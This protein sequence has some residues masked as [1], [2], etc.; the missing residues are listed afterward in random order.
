[1]KS[2]KV[3]SYSHFRWHGEDVIIYFIDKKD[4]NFIEAMLLL[5][6]WEPKN[7]SIDKLEKEKLKKWN[8]KK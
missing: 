5:K 2:G 3:K 4:T 8:R 1:M 7:N 6:Y